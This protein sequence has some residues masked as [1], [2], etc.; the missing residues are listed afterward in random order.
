MNI[1]ALMAFSLV[2]AAPS[3]AIAPIDP[4]LGSALCVTPASQQGPALVSADPKPGVDTWIYENKI[5]MTFSEKVA[6][7]S[8]VVTDSEGCTVS[9]SEE[10]S[11]ESNKLV[12]HMKACKR[13]GYPG[14]NMA[15]RY[16]VNGVAGEYHLHIR[17]HH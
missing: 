11:G 7:H 17:H 5:S 2:V 16:K 14:G 10:V 15:V 9:Q 13:M 4:L 12:V 8:V 1:L 6:D 3:T